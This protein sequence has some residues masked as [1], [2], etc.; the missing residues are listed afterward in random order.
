MSEN[1]AEGF[2]ININ[3]FFQS[4]LLPGFFFFQGF[5]FFISKVSTFQKLSTKM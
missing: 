5:F 4:A 2:N 3:I 1:L